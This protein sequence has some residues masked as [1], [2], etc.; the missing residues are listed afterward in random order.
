MQ[1]MSRCRTTGQDSFLCPEPQIPLGKSCLETA[2][3]A[4][5]ELLWLGSWSWLTSLP[6][7]CLWQPEQLFYYIVRGKLEESGKAGDVSR[8]TEKSGG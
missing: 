4:P 8:S 1:G 6:H 5:A 3:V 7:S 2:V